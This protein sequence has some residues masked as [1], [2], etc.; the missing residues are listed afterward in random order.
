MKKLFKKIIISTY[1][2]IFLF[3]LLVPFSK[4]FAQ[5]ATNRLVISANP[6]TIVKDKPT[7]V[8]ANV[9]TAVGGEVVSFSVNTPL[10]NFPTTCT[11]DVVPTNQSGILN[12]PRVKSCSVVFTTGTTGNNTT[13]SASVTTDGKKYSSNFKLSDVLKCDPKQN[14]VNGVCVDPVVQSTST[15]TNTTYTPLAPLPGLDQVP[16]ETNPDLNPCPFGQYLN[17][18]IK[19]IIGIAAVLAMIMIV[20][21]GIEYMTSELV[22]GKE[23]GKETITNAILGLLIALG[24]FLILNTINPQLL[25]VCLKLAPATIVIDDLGGES[26]EPFVPINKTT[27]KNTFGIDCEGNDG[28]GNTGRNAVAGIAKEFINKTIYSQDKRNTTTSSKIYVDC[29]SFAAQVYVCAGLPSPGGR[30]TD[31]FSS[32]NTKKVDGATFDFTT[33][34]SGDLI[35]WKPGDNG[36]KNGHVMIYLG[37]GQMIDTQGT[38]GRDPAT[39]TNVRQLSDSLKKRIKYAKWP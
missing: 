23:A 27:L 32:G 4:S 20:T 18:M 30:S 9:Y 12:A 34:H 39:A 5:D 15:P 31:I 24:S 25:N 8:T 7:T 19:L 3:G 13:I 6:S 16:F 28:K 29:S 22:S 37:N 33:L 38:K 17:I 11:I 2:I 10:S 26:S 36:D 35:G 21:G 1:L 14:L